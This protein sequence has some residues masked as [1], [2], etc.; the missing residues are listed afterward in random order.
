MNVEQELNDRLQAIRQWC[1]HAEAGD[2]EP[3]VALGAVEAIAKKATE[4]VEAAA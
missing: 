1:D 4:I 2:V 3:L